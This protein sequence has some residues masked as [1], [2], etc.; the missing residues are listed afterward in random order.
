[1]KHNIVHKKVYEINGQEKV[2][3]VRV[4][5][6]IEKDSG[7]SIKLDYVPTQFDGWL[8]AYPDEKKDVTDASGYQKAKATAQEIKSR[9]V[10][11]VADVTD[12]PI[13]LSSIPF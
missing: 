2:V 3:W 8:A 11:T 12:D 1:M 4:G 6:L 9:Q 10:D 7:Y 5:V 13:D